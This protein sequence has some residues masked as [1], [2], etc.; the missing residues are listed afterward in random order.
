[1]QNVTLSP[2]P[3]AERK[4]D[5]IPVPL[6]RG[7]FGLVLVSLALTT[8]AVATGRPHEGQPVDAAIVTERSIILKGGGAQSV[9]VLDAEGNLI[10]DMPH[11][12]FITVVQNA[13][14][15]QRK[16]NGI[17]PLLPVRVV[18]YANGRVSVQ[19]PVNGWGVETQGFGS[20]NEAAFRRLLD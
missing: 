3:P 4:P 8:Y 9:T 7:M 11:G 5:M 6:V 12:G 10:L 2:A 15:T 17:D 13:L 1:M 19:D 16:R 20:D 14:E 18:E